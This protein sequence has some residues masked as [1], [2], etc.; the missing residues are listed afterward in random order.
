ML[1]GLRKI[2]VMMLLK[3]A[4]SPRSEATNMLV[5]RTSHFQEATIRPIYIVPRHKHS[6]V[7]IAHHALNFLPHASSEIISN[8]FHIF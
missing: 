1:H 6:V 4:I 8:Y 7:F 3:K 5:L 2:A